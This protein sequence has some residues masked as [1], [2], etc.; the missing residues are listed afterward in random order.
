MAGKTG[1]HENFTDAWFVGFIPQYTTA[2]WVGFP[3]RQIEMRNLT[4]R[5]TFY[6]RV[7]GSAIPAPI[8]RQFMTVVT[9]DL[10]IEDFPENPE[11]TA[12]YYRTMRVAIP[13][14]ED[15]DLEDAT[16]ELYN[17]GLDF[18]VT[19]VNSDKPADTAI[20]T[21][22]PAGRQ[23][24]QGS[25]IELFVSSG[26]APEAAMPDLVGRTRG[27]ADQILTNLRQ[28]TQ[29]EF[30]WTFIEVA[31]DDPENDDRVSSTSPASTGTITEG[32][33][34]Q[35]FVYALEGG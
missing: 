26:L 24:N 12:A 14:V 7:F 34:I 17:A 13:D 32:T 2:V 4:I 19:I 25:T 30:S 28:A 29:I 8:W 27:E 18:T 11:G 20:E 33:E 9:A 31:T 15:M 22:P 3:D 16:D 35:V 6:A 21:E 23:I 1:T 10:P 5:D